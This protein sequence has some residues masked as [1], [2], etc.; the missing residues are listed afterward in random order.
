MIPLWRGGADDHVTNCHFLCAS[1]TRATR[2]EEIERIREIQKRREEQREDWREQTQQTQQTQHT[3]T[4]GR[5][6]AGVPYFVHRC[7]S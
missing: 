5:R 7:T 1:A 4:C 6:A 2:S 3:L